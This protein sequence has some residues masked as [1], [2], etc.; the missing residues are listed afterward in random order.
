MSH[1]WAAQTGGTADRVLEPW[2]PGK[3]FWRKRRLI[4]SEVE[5]EV[6]RAEGLRQGRLGSRSR[7]C[8]AWS[9]AR[10]QGQGRTRGQ[11][12]P[13][14]RGG[15][16]GGGTPGAGQISIPITRVAVPQ[17]PCS[18]PSGSLG[19]N[20]RVGHPK[21]QPQPQPRTAALEPE[22]KGN[23]SPV[24]TFP[25]KCPPKSN[26]VDEGTT[27]FYSQNTGVAIKSFPAPSG[28]TAVNAHNTAGQGPTWADEGSHHIIT[29]GR[30]IK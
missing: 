3:G 6:G 8:K 18:A 14:P 16:A 24:C 2:R 29:P 26:R 7:R 13:E 10:P 27:A 15:G 12:W 23:M 1:T 9:G 17:L 28:C 19:R 25:Q 5:A 22:A 11:G 21:S 30:K 4:E 20:R